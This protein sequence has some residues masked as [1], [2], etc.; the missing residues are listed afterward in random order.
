M[1]SVATQATDRSFFGHPRGLGLLFAA[2]MWERFSFYG[3]RAL[4]VLY[5][6]NV[7]EWDKVSA[8]SLYGTYT[9]LVYLTPLI[10][11]YLADRYIGTHRA[12]L[13]GGAVI[14]AGHFVLALPGMQAF[15][16]GLG[17]VVIGTGFFKANVSTM[18]GQLYEAGDTRRDS[19]FTLFYMGINT[20]GFLGP[21]VCGYLAQSPQ[22]GWHY[23]FAAAGVG[24]VL[25]LI[26]Y[27]LLKRK[28]LGSIGDI[29]AARL[30]PAAA[31]AEV[32]SSS[33]P[34]QSVRNGIIGA[35]VGGVVA[36]LISG[37]ILGVAVG[38]TI[39]GALAISV[40]GT[41]GEERNRVIALFI[42]AFFVVF[43]WAAFEQ[44]GS[45]MSLFADKNTNLQ[46]GSFTIPSSW[47]QSVNSFFII[48]FAPIFAWMWVMV[49]K[50]GLEPSTPLKMSI[51]LALIAIGFGILMIGGGQAD[52]GVKVSPMFLI[53][54][55]L[56]HTFG[57]LCLSPVG[58][59][60]VTKVAPVRFAS[61]LMGVWFLANAAANKVAGF[62]AGYTPLPGEAPAAP[63]AGFGGYIQQLAGTNRGF[64]SI[65]VVSSLAAAVVLFF[66]VPLLKRLTRTVKA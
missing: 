66:C 38:A 56:F 59:S 53:G 60:Y 18:V 42:V 36:W 20:G 51:G 2:E 64:F 35:V 8:A 34:D 44:A 43:F 50:R 63:E 57:E 28:Y 31:T 33:L 46:L 21:L 39:G 61:L 16:A 49:G 26:M 52:T 7:L 25:G 58:L 55:F 5:L 32:T 11:G 54:A 24:M 17:L 41:T 37:S 62:L 12:L 65:F 13:I 6:V 48:T 4:L 15:Y 45:S 10:G 30:A 22:F 14:S 47:F 19:G 27:S 9:M 29:P 3:M 1:T 23:G 40:L